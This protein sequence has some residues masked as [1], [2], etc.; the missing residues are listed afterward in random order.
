[1]C[2]WAFAGCTGQLGEGDRQPVEL[3]KLRVQQMFLNTLKANQSVEG[4]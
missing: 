4:F 2:R 1:M 3:E